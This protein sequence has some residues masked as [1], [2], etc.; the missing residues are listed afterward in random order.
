VH[1]LLTND[2]GILAPGIAAMWRELCTLGEVTVVAPES[3]QSAAGHSITV[4]DAVIA[5]RVHVN[6][7][8]YGYSVVG[9][10]A[11]CVKVAVRELLGTPADLVVSGINAGANVGINILYSGTVAAAAEAAFYRLPAVAVSLEYRAELDFV[12]AARIARR[13]I[14]GL[15]QA[16]PRPGWL[17]NV[18]IPALD[19][20]PPRGVRVVRQ[21]TQP[22]EERFVKAKDPRGRT[23][24]WLT[25]GFADQGEP[26]TDLRAISEGYV[27]VTPLRFDLTRDDELDVM[28][29]WRWPTIED[30]PAG[31]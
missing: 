27:A 12:H 11:D 31:P 29:Q 13:V 3:P 22:M 20:G 2:D 26:D 30:R 7:E 16:G 8:F 28:R 15:I 6:D 9:R 21:S 10:P 24:F 23:Y 17:I 4:G 25:G 18:N 5:S 19:G 1:I 14:A